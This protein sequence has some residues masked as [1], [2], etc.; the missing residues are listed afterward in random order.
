M[1]QANLR[2]HAFAIASIVFLLVLMAVFSHKEVTAII[3]PYY[4]TISNA[5]YGYNCKDT[6]AR[7]AASGTVDPFASGLPP[8]RRNNV[9]TKVS[10]LCNGKPSCGITVNSD[11]LGGDPAPGCGKELEVEYRCFSYDRPRMEKKTEAT[12][13]EIDCTNVQFP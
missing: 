10:D 12:R 3:S 5:T 7:A 11:V 4:I 8:I 2:I 13:L 9:L 6:E 1:N